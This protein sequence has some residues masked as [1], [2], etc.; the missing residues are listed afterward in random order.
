MRTLLGSFLAILI[1]FGSM[2]QIK[3]KETQMTLKTVNSD[4]ETITISYLLDTNG[5]CDR[6][7][8]I[9]IPPLVEEL[10]PFTIEQLR[11]SALFRIKLFELVTK[12]HQAR[13][14]TNCSLNWLYINEI[15]FGD[16]DNEEYITFSKSEL[17]WEK[18]NPPPTATTEKTDTDAK[19]ESK[20][21]MLPLIIILLGGF[22]L[23]FI[24][25]LRLRRQVARLE[26]QLLDEE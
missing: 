24:L 3:A 7:E 8:E 4:G 13:V 1:F 17:R 25:Y 15:R 19:A 11:D 23:F 5:L 16:N 12:H 2:A 10:K 22:C 20:P 14:P 26:A 18:S 6:L 21:L 9:V